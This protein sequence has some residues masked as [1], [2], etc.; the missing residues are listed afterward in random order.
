MPTTAR[1]DNVRFVT[2]P[3]DSGAAKGRVNRQPRLSDQVADLITGDILELGLRPGD[4]L[5]SEREL[6]EKYGVSRTVVR[7]AVRA[8]AAK[9]LVTARTGSGIQVSA[10]AAETVSESMKLFL[11]GRAPIEYEQLHDVR[12]T[13]EL[14]IAA[15]AAERASGEGVAYLTDICESMA[16]ALDDVDASSLRDLEFH[17]AIAEISGNPLYVVLLDALSDALLE[18]RR[19]TI[20][21]EP[22]RPE[23]VL[24]AHRTIR[25]AIAAHDVDGAVEA[26]QC[27][28]ADIKAA[29]DRVA[30]RRTRPAEVLPA[31]TAQL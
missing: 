25:D 4:R 20:A 9:G 30:A 5:P 18:T 8:L 23:T 17:R 16:D 28:L 22:G 27:H 15:R 26:M 7:E 6:G 24:A 10:V 11:L 31:A 12:S 14:A 21:S 3:R 2:S 1:T 19:Q 29:W 13:L